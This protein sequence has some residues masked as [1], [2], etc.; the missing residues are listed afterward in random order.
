MP[1]NIRTIY[2]KNIIGKNCK[3]QI[4]NEK[5]KMP[6]FYCNSQ[7]FQQCSIINEYWLGGKKTHQNQSTVFN[8][9]LLIQP[10]IDCNHLFIHWYRGSHFCFPPKRKK[11]ENSFIRIFQFKS[12][13]NRFRFGLVWFG[14]FFTG[15]KWNSRHPSIE[16]ET[17]HVS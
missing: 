3:L 12:N 8:I 5:W 11:T 16:L 7:I 14:K 9:D 6:K 4:A 17:E 13:L 15:F 2:K 10:L 1:P